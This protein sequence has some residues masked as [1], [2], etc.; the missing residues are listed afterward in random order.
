MRGDTAQGTVAFVMEECCNCGMP[1]YMT[2]ALQKRL[3]DQRPAEFF[4][5]QGHPQWY[6]GKTEAQKLKDKLAATKNEVAWYSGQLR[7]EREIRNHTERRLAA[8]KGH[9]TR[10]KNRLIEGNCPCC[11]A[12]FDDL[13]THI[14]VIHPDFELE[15]ADSIIAKPQPASRAE[16]KATA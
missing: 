6:T 11:D 2:A 4:C 3:L 9:L 8:T 5:P 10:A 16:R 14:K 12:H 13:E 7:D 15:P 1:F